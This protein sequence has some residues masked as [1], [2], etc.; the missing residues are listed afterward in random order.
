MATC[1][2]PIRR[3]ASLGD[4]IVGTGSADKK[5]VN[6]G[7]FLV[8]AMRVSE[9][10]RFD[11]YWN[12]PRF[13]KKKPHLYGSYMTACGDNIYYPLEDGK[14][15]QLDSY[16]SEKDG[17]PHQGHIER[18]TKIDRVL[19]SKDFIYFGGEGPKIPNSLKRLVQQGRGYRRLRYQNIEHR[20]I[21][22]KFETWLNVLDVKG[23]R[24]RPFDMI[25]EARKGKRK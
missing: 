19:V 22:T 3:Y 25:K 15:E 7:G 5:K 9:T 11:Q 24:G 16:H 8:Y 12:D 23:Y 10:L 6:R 4:W 2:P 1:K 20:S 21:I 17:S 13:K 18:D 14:W